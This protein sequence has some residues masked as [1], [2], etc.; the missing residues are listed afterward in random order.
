MNV[1]IKVKKLLKVYSSMPIQIKA[2]IW[3]VISTVLL[4]GISFITVPIFTRVMTSEQYGIYSVYLS[5]FDIFSII[6]TL[7]IEGAALISGLTKYEGE[8]K[9]NFKLSLLELS[10]LVTTILLILVIIG[11]NW[12]SEIIG[13]SKVMLLLLVAQVY[14]IPAVNF[15]LT[16]K[17][18]EY[19]YKGVVFVSISMAITNAF[20]GLLLVMNCFDEQ[21]AFFRVI[22]IVVVQAIYGVVLLFKLLKKTKLHLH[23]EYWR[24][25]L[26]LQLPFLPH[27]L[28]L[29]VL[30]SADRIMINSLV[31]ST[32]AA[33]YSVAYS[34]SVIVNLIKTSIV[35]ALRPWMYKTLKEEKYKEISPVTNGIILLVCILTIICIAFAPEIIKFAAPSNYYVAIYCIPPVM[36]SSFFTFLYSVFSIVELY[37]EETKKIMI[38]SIASAILNIILNAVLIPFFGYI[39][40]A[41]TTLICYIFLSFTHYFMVRKILINKNIKDDLFDKR[42]LISTC[43]IMLSIMVVFEFIYGMLLVRYAFLFLILV[44][45]FVKRN[46]F[47]SLIK[48]VRGE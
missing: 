37:F 31:N 10:F 14:F 20:I 16:E 48:M 41:Y 32:A 40:A 29:K 39:V 13:L 2:S 30:A 47:I 7:S 24:W 23:T 28:S 21:Q 11:Q 42:I 35:D 12:L 3:F 6:G 9:N 15:W 43:S 1:V 44:V 33:I 36:M 18:F 19:S 5:W 38:A 17:R 34:V 4:K 22:S 27:T 45:L 46:Y 25:A 26:K 8:K